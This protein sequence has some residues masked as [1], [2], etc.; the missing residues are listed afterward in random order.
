[1]KY[2]DTTL[3]IFVYGTLRHRQGNWWHHLRGRTGEHERATVSGARLWAGP[4]FPF[5]SLTEE[6]DD[7]VVGEVHWLRPETAMSTL[8]RLDDLEGFRAGR[9]DNLFDRVAVWARL[10]DGDVAAWMFVVADSGRLAI[11]ASIPS[12]DWLTHVSSGGGDDVGSGCPSSLGRTAG[13][14]APGHA[15]ETGRFGSTNLTLHA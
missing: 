9:P 8:Q 10:A 1:M 13:Q 7:F 2:S 11:L 14:R 5:A 12:G 6:A 3:P 15:A 4:G